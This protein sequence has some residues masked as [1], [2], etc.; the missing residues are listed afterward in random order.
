MDYLKET[1]DS[2]VAQT[3]KDYEIVIVDDGSTD[4]TEDMIK[5]LDY[6]IRYCWQENRGD[7]AARNRLIELAQG[8]YI[9]FIDSD[10]VLLPDAIERMVDAIKAESDDVVVYGSYFRI[11]QDGK[12]CGRS[13]RRLYTGNITKYLFQDIFVHCC[14]SMLPKKLLD[15]AATFNSSLKVCSDYDLW[16]RLSMKHRFVALADPTFKRRRHS[17]NLSTNSF[18]NCLAQFQVLERFYY[19][20]GGREVVPPKTAEKVLG[21]QAYRAGRRAF[22]EG[23][24]EEACQLLRQ[25]FVCHPGLRSLINWTRAVLAKRLTPMQSSSGEQ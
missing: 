20:K 11:D 7:A 2:V 8:E 10:D 17:G 9:S 13:R 12:I 5:N 1:L 21:K 15:G 22:K 23:L 4:G 14:G 25:S 16:L 6:P 18:A 24:R 3:Y 19:E